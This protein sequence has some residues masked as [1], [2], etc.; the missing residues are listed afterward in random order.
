MSRKQ[1]LQGLMHAAQQGQKMREGTDYANK[2]LNETGLEAT[3]P[4]Q[5]GGNFIYDPQNPNAN[6]RGQMD[7]SE[8][9]NREIKVKG[10]VLQPAGDNPIN[11]RAQEEQRRREKNEAE[12]RRL[13]GPD[14]A[15]NREPVMPSEVKNE[16]Y[17]NRLNVILETILN[18]MEAKYD[19]GTKEDREAEALWISKQLARGRDSAAYVKQLAREKR[20]KRRAEQAKKK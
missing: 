19:R 7:P 16:A 2:T 4:N 1:M 10:Q 13:S 17:E 9:H 3:K 5:M 18:V 8:V 14:A 11:K 12:M 15:I 6:L 20:A